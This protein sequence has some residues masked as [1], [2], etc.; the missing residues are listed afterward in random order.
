MRIAELLE[1]IVGSQNMQKYFFNNDIVSLIAD[2]AG[3]M[4]KNEA[5]RFIMLLDYAQ[6]LKIQANPVY[7]LIYV[8]L[9]LILSNIFEKHIKVTV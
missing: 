3:Y 6:S 5:I 8:K 1:L 7:K 4:E 2:L 9:E